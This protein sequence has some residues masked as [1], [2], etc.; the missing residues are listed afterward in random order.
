MGEARWKAWRAHKAQAYNGGL[1]LGS[2]RGAGS[3]P[4]A[5]ESGGEIP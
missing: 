5:R 2:R 3:E 4:L 1:G